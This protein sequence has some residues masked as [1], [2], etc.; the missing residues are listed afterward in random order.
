MGL[1]PDLPDWFVEL[2]SEWQ[3]KTP[4]QQVDHI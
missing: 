2:E 1:S 3:T 4:H